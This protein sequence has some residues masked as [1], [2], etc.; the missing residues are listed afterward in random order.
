MS[1]PADV[2]GRLGQLEGVDPVARGR[3]VQLDHE[4]VEPVGDAQ[5][6]RWAHPADPVY[7]PISRVSQ[8]I[9]RIDAAGGQEAA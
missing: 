6:F 3:F 7:R 2:P 1:S 5:G 9:A 8:E 4:G